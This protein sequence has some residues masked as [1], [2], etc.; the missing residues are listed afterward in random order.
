[1][2]SNLLVNALKFTPAG[3]VV[4][5]SVDRDNGTARLV[6]ADTGIGIPEEEQSRVFER[7]WRG[8]GARGVAGS[9]IG[10]TV[11]SEL[12]HAHGGDVSVESEP[13]HGTRVTVRIPGR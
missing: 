10:L 13:G 6:V 11:V 12:A 9:G 3:G 4:A 5:V 1:M 8:S 2:T 7:F